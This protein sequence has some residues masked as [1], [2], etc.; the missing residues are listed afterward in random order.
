MVIFLAGLDYPNKY[1]LKLI[2][3]EGFL[4]GLGREGRVGVNKSIS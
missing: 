2:I 4:H 3:W 1:K